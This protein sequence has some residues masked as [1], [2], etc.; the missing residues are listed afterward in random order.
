MRSR[1]REG[2]RAR[3]RA[4]LSAGVLF[5]LLVSLLG[6][7]WSAQAE[8][9]APAAVGFRVVDGRLV[10]SNGND[11]VMRGVNHAHAWYPNETDS[12]ADIKA[13][14]ANTVRVVLSNGTRWTRNDVA[15]VANVVSLCKANRLICVLEVHDTTGYGEE[16]AA[17]TLAQAAQYWVDVRSALVGQEDYVIVNI[18]N[19]P[20]GNTN[21]AGWANDTRGAIQTLRNAGLDHTI[22]V[23]APNWGQDWSGTMRSN[24]QSVFAADVDRNTIFSVH[25]Y[26]VYDTAAEIRDYLNAYVSAGLPVLVG[27]FGHNHSDGNPDEDTIMSVTQQLGLGYIG[28]SWSG[29]G[30]GVEYLDLVNG[31]D[32]NSLSSWGQRFFTGANGIS[33]TSEEAAVYGGGGNPGDTQAPTAPGAPAASEVTASSVRLS[34]TAATDN[35]AVTRY[36]I[37]RVSGSTETQVASSSANSVSVT[38]LSADTAYTFAVYARDAA[39]NRSPRSSAVSVTTRDGGG[40]P[41]ACSVGYAIVG[42]WSNGF[43][44]EIVIGNTGSAAISGWTLA[45]SFADGQSIGNMWGGTSAQSGGAVTVTPASYTATIPAGGSVTLGFTASKGSANAEPSEF[46][47]SG[48]A[49][50]T[51]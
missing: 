13:K 39:G 43:Q 11:F 14:G 20:Y 2:R 47:L 38:G 31:F 35:V 21:T 33:Q 7:G 30:G 28:W 50:S 32:P 10:E 44:G 49:C 16:G 24:A 23:D 17:A 18:G 45:F 48:G 3:S 37:V 15:D 51:S 36:D 26:G 8:P 6:L 19:E 12:F 5:A 42:E 4:G 9:V 27:E 41:A 40:T 1:T 25:M 22:M 46:T 34:W 29:N